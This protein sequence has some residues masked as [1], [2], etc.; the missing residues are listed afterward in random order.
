MEVGSEHGVKENYSFAR[1]NGSFISP[2]SVA[3]QGDVYRTPETT[4]NNAPALNQTAEYVVPHDVEL[5]TL[6]ASSAKNLPPGFAKLPSPAPLQ[7]AGVASNTSLPSPRRK[8][9]SPTPFKK[10][11]PVMQENASQGN[12]GFFPQEFVLPHKSPSRRSPPPLRDVDGLADLFQF[13]EH[14]DQV[15]MYDGGILDTR[16]EHGIV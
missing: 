13:S 9:E 3:L 16:L 1:A 10:R 4:P 8:K 7:P 11:S 5:E 6:A 15:S 2:K 14:G 12:S